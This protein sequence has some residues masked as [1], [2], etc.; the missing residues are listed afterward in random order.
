M[1]QSTADI[2]RRS[3]EKRGVRPK[4]YKLPV[5]TIELIATLSAQ[6]GQPQ[7]AIIAE[8]VRLYASTIQK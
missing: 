7:S 8:A 2:Q 4:G 5:E 3:D 6:T 1:A